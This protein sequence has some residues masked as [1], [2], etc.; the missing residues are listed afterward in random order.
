ML[1]EYLQASSGVIPAG[2][3]AALTAT[4]IGAVIG[5]P[6]MAIGFTAAAA[7]GL[8]QAGLTVAQGVS[9]Y[10]DAK[11]DGMSGKEAMKE[12][13]REVGQGLEEFVGHAALPFFHTIQAAGKLIQ[14][15][16]A[17]AA[18]MVR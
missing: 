1:P 3:G 12:A 17:L 18:H 2:F 16:G 7:G 8:L 15:G 5:A 4:G 14:N 6:L 13:G 10:R 9:A 11:A